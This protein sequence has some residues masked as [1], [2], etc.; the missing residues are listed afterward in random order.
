VTILG[1][2]LL[3]LSGNGVGF[4]PLDAAADTRM[5]SQ[6][7]LSGDIYTSL[8]WLVPTTRSKSVRFWAHLRLSTDVNALGVNGP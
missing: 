7:F 3:G 8:R 2:G 4:V 5:E 6:K 1:L